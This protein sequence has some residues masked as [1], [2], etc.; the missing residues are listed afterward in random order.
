MLLFVG[1]GF[2]ATRY[3]ALLAVDANDDID[4]GDAITIDGATYEVAG[5]NARNRVPSIR[6]TYYGTNMDCGVEF[7]CVELTTQYNGT[8]VNGTSPVVKAFDGETQGTEYQFV[9]EDATPSAPTTNDVHWPVI[10]SAR[11][12]T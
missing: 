7:T 5:V 3:F 1:D 10:K 12:T 8:Q 9:V 6:D 2:D 11:G 4:T